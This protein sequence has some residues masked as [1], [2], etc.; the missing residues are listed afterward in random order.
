MV[1]MDWSN[2]LTDCIVHESGDVL[3]L[4]IESPTWVGAL[5]LTLQAV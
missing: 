2:S 3:R 5:M 4:L 1:K